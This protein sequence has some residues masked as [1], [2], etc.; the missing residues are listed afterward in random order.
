[1]TCCGDQ[2]VRINERNGRIFCANCRVYLDSTLRRA[3][4]TLRDTETA[5]TSVEPPV[6]ET[7]FKGDLE[8]TSR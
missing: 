6:Q 4:D 8:G 7:L 5:K 3:P 2:K 1:M